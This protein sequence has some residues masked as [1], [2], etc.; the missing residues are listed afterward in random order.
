MGAFLILQSWTVKLQTLSAPPLPSSSPL[1]LWQAE[2][3]GGKA[4]H[5]G[6]P[7]ANSED[8]EQGTCF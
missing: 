8:L 7:N 2:A 3:E 6:S 5:L 4:M 1:P